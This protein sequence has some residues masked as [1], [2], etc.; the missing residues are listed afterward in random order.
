MATYIKPALYFLLGVI[1]FA[2]DVGWEIVLL[3]GGV[4]QVARIA[5]RFEGVD[6]KESDGLFI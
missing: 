4:I 3:P 5:V 6:L 2:E 1:V